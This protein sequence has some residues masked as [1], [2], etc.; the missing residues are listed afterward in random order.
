MQEDPL[1]PRYRSG[2]DV[3]LAIGAVRF[4]FNRDDFSRRV[5]AAAARLGLVDMATVGDGD[6]ADLTA[7]AIGGHRHGADGELARHLRQIDH[8]LRHDGRGLTHWLR[9]L[10]LRGAWIDQLVNEGHLDPVFVPGR[11]FAYRAPGTGAPTA[12]DAGAPDWSAHVFRRT[13]A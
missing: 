10:V 9:R 1:A 7:I 11:G 3:L 2:S 6:R 12:D 5:V 8:L 13:A 4:E